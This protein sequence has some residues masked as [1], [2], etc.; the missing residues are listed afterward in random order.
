[1]VTFSLGGL[2]ESSCRHLTHKADKFLCDSSEIRF[3]I[4]LQHR[5]IALVNEL[6]HCDSTEGS[7]GSQ[8]SMEIALPPRLRHCQ[9]RWQDLPGP[10]Q[11][12]GPSACSTILSWMM[13][14][15]CS[16]QGHDRPHRSVYA[17]GPFWKKPQVPSSSA[18][19]W[20]HLHMCST[21]LSCREVHGTVCERKS[22]VLDRTEVPRASDECSPDIS[23]GGATELA[24]GL[25]RCHPSLAAGRDLLAVQAGR[26]LVQGARNTSYSES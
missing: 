10:E 14:S 16:T 13:M 23:H 24:Q 4:H 22:K 20:R 12:D 15:H 26:R 2:R 21:A 5:I 25:D 9:V 18:L 11:R 7:E 6:D 1:M 17:A 3:C 19:A 8:L